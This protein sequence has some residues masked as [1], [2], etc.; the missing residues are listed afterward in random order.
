MDV[1]LLN[2]EVEGG[3]HVLTDVAPYIGMTTVGD[4]K[5]ATMLDYDMDGFLDIYVPSLDFGSLIYHNKGNANHWIG[6][7]LEGT[8]SNRDAIGTLVTC[9][10]GGKKQMRYTRVPSTWK[11][12]DNQFVHFGIGTTA[13]IDSI[14]IRWPLGLKEVYTGLALD[15]YH[16][17][18]EGQGSS[19]VA[20]T[21]LTAPETF[22]LEQNH[23]NPFNPTT[24][25]RYHVSVASPITLTIFNLAGERVQTLVNAEFKPAGNYSVLWNG[26]D[27][28]GRSAPSGV[29]LYRLETGATMQVKKMTLMK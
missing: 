28:A 22:R 7:I 21:P 19:E 26:R 29:Y 24:T 20:A 11:I 27:Q 12:Q 8:Q 6:M 23:P 15:R 25:I 2:E 1:L 10:A 16:R 14:V 18:K 9:Y 3:L 5:G 13:S 17:I 4:R